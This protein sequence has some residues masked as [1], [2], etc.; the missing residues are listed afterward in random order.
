MTEDRWQLCDN[1]DDLF[2]E[3]GARINERKQRLFACGSCRLIE[4]LLPDEPSQ[5]AIDLMEHFADGT[6]NEAEARAARRSGRIDVVNAATLWA[7]EAVAALTSFRYRS[8]PIHVEEITCH[9]ARAARD[10][11][12]QSDW[13]RARVKQA[14]VVRDL[15]RYP[16]RPPVVFD[17]AWLHWQNGLVVQMARTIYAEYRF[18]ELPILGDALEE[19]GCDDREVLDHCRNQPVHVRGCWLIDRLL[20]RD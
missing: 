17:P 16:A 2:H 7:A 5:Y 12:G 13:G 14:A 4:S 1:P 11:A 19:A 15:L 18:T 9:A 20:G 6:V 8:L 10:A 3:L